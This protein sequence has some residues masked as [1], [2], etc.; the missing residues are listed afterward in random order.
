MSIGFFCLLL[1]KPLPERSRRQPRVL[2]EI[3]AEEGERG[4]IQLVADFAD[5]LLSVEQLVRN[6]LHGSFGNPVEC[7]ATAHSLSGSRQLVGGDKQL[8]G[9]LFHFSG[10]AA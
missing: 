7:R 8:L 10:A 9:K 1:P 6:G 3:L 2:L 4:E 5:G